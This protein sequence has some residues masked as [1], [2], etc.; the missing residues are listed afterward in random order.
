MLSLFQFRFL[1]YSALLL[2]LAASQSFAASGT[3]SP[4]P[5]PPTIL[6]YGDSLSAA[7]GIPREQGWVTLLQHQLKRQSLQH[8]VIN[9]SISGETTSGGLT[10]LKQL[11]DQ[12]QPDLVLLQLG[13]NDGLRGLPVADMRRNLAAMIEISQKSGAK[14]ALLGVMIPPNYGP[15]YTQEFRESYSMLARQY[16]LPLVP[17]MLEG[18]AGKGELMQDDGLHPTAA[19]QVI[20]LD[21]IWKVLAPHFRSVTAGQ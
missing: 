3:K 7:Y 16:K 5:E 19:A 6:V 9:A 2:F 11:L 15:R 21:N 18:V 4:T 8:Q 10:R 20:V 13:A 12:Y 1:K 17:F 14:V